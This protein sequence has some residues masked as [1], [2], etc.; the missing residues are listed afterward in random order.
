MYQ[1]L[2][3]DCTRPRGP[4]LRALLTTPQPPSVIPDTFPELL[5]LDMDLLENIIQA[6]SHTTAFVIANLYNYFPKIETFINVRSDQ[7]SI[8]STYCDMARINACPSQVTRIHMKS[9]EEFAACT[10]SS[11]RIFE[12]QFQSVKC[13][14]FFSRGNS[15]INFNHDL[16]DYGNIGNRLQSFTFMTGNESDINVNQ[17]DQL[18]KL[19]KALSSGY[20]QQLDHEDGTMDSIS[21]ILSFS[22]SERRFHENQLKSNRAIGKFF[23]QLL[24]ISAPLTND[25]LAILEENCRQLII[26]VQRDQVPRSLSVLSGMKSL[27]LLIIE[28]PITCT[29]FFEF[30]YFLLAYG[31]NLVH[32]GVILG[33]ETSGLLGIIARTCINLTTFELGFYGI[34]PKVPN[35]P[36]WTIFSKSLCD[37][38]RN[39]KS[40]KHLHFREPRFIKKEDEALLKYE[41]AQRNRN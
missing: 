21:D 23:A 5:T 3:L 10:R 41:I 39:F 34:N 9:V 38:I 7:L 8:I 16:A 6:P 20:L 40:I 14:T 18:L 19:L 31:A 27:K 28:A 25:L 37:Q 33:E 30:R 17:Y 4:L 11:L 2:P 13:M 12:L 22:E 26:F 36:R 1:S 29:Q 24:E 32:L 15:V 35:N